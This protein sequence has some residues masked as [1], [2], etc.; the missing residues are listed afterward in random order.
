MQVVSLFPIS[1]VQPKPVVKRFG[2]LDD[3]ALA[4]CDKVLL[5]SVKTIYQGFYAEKPLYWPYSHRTFNDKFF[6]RAAAIFAVY[7]NLGSKNLSQS[8]MQV[9]EVTLKVVD[10]LAKYIQQPKFCVVE[11]P[12]NYACE[13]DEGAI[14]R[15]GWETAHVLVEAYFKLKDNGEEVIKQKIEPLLPEILSRLTSFVQNLSNLRYQTE[16]HGYVTQLASVYK[17]LQEKK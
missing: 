2:Q 14:Q 8:G 5:D 6:E 17:R 10:R 15:C 3:A 1:P 7:S 13:N 16:N 4:E 11:S 12:K 9:Q